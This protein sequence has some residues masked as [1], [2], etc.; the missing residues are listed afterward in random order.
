[1]EF[2]LSSVLSG[3][4]SS[5]IPFL[6]LPVLTWFSVSRVMDRLDRVAYSPGWRAV[7]GVVAACLPWIITVSLVGFSVHLIPRTSPEDFGCYVK[8]YG[9]LVIILGL[10]MRAA[11]VCSWKYRN[12]R[13]LLRLAV[14]PSQRLRDVS[15]ELGAT[16]VE[17]GTDVPARIAMG[18]LRPR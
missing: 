17:L 8:V 18:V 16:A 7:F 3:P 11:V 1:M 15:N 5:V 9:P 4:Y 6:F 12:V 10:G 2:C 13:H 14:E